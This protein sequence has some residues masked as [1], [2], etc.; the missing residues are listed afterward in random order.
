[1][2]DAEVRSLLKQGT[3]STYSFDPQHRAEIT[4]KNLDLALREIKKLM[5]SKGRV[6]LVIVKE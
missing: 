5:T 1:M 6:S 2:T 4:R 3:T